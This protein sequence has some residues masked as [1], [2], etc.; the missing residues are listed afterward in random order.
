MILKVHWI[1]PERVQVE[2]KDGCVKPRP[3]RVRTFV[4]RVP[5]VVAVDS[6]LRWEGE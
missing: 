3:R 2:V 1:S 5:G 4:E 6:R